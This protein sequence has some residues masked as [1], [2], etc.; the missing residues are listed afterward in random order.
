MVMIFVFRQSE[1]CCQTTPTANVMA[2]VNAVVDLRMV[3]KYHI[4]TYI[5]QHCSR[6]S[7]QFIISMG[8]MAPKLVILKEALIDSLSSAK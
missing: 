3:T 4:L 5:V 1:F 6:A 7:G 8:N 2:F